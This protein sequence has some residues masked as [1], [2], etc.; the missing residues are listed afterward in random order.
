[1][2]AKRKA[3]VLFVCTGNSCRSQMAEGWARRLGADAVAAFSAGTDPIGVLA[4]TVATM[5]AAGVDISRQRSKALET[6]AGEFL[7]ILSRRIEE[8]A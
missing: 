2:T 8:E 6:F 4:E 1:M 3:R 7:G 5:A